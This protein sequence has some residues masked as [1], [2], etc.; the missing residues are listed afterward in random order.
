MLEELYFHGSF[1][2]LPLLKWRWVGSY[3]YT[4]VSPSLQRET[5]LA[6]FHSSDT[7]AEAEML[8]DG[9]EFGLVPFDVLSN[10]SRRFTNA[11]DTGF[12]ESK[13]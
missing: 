11:A 6:Y 5:T 13:D 7:T 2:D 12:K 4:S 9:L 10:L 3:Q 1:D 8:G